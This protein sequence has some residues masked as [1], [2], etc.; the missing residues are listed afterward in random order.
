MYFIEDVDVS[1]YC[2]FHYILIDMKCSAINIGIFQLQKSYF[3]LY[4]EQI[5]V[6]SVIGICINTNANDGR[7]M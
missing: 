7:E 3:F 6:R 1:S 5:I 4:S 2:E